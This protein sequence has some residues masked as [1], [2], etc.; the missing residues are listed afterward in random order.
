MEKPCKRAGC[1]NPV[2]DFKQAYCSRNC[3]P[4]GNPL[5]TP[6]SVAAPIKR[7]SLYRTPAEKLMPS[8]ADLKRRIR[9]RARALPIIRRFERGDIEFEQMF[10]QLR[11]KV[12]R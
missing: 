1:E 7:P 6:G 5:D 2:R 3:A 9:H 12:L 4:L 8:A 10:E 11:T